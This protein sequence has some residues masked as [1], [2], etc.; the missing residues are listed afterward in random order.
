MNKSK[1]RACDGKQAHPNRKTALEHLW[2]LVREG[3]SPAVLNVYAC[4]TVKPGQVR[5]FH[6]GHRMPG[7]RK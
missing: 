5:H 1:A 3:A 2:R 6:V 4:P 7:R